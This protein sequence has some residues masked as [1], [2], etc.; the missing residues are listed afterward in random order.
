MPV[1]LST[2]VSDAPTS[3]PF[4]FQGGYGL[5]SSEIGVILSLQGVYQMFTQMI[6]FPFI[7]RRL[8]ALRT[9]KLAAFCWGF[10]YLVVP[11]LVLL[12]SGLRMPGLALVLI[13]KVTLQ[14]ISYPSNALVLANSAPSLMVLGA[15]NGVAAS[16]AS[17]CRAFGPTLAG[18]FQS[19]GSSA[20]YSG[21][22]WWISAGVCGI[23]AVETLWMI[24]PLGRPDLRVAKCA[25][26]EREIRSRRQSSETLCSESTL[27]EEHNQALLAD[28]ASEKL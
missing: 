21:L 2:K 9:F 19:L 26:G 15:I 16:A 20:G 7:V 24:E 27:V 28:E 5:P 22:A 4:K 6:V 23:G 8:G 11:Y 25:S 14:S 13:S 12:P 10:L 1:L 3:L 17:L 18:I